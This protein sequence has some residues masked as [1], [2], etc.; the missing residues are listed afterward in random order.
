MGSEKLQ[1]LVRMENICGNNILNHAR[2]SVMRGEVAGVLGMNNAGKTELLN[3]LTGRQRPEMGTVYFEDRP[4]FISSPACANALGIY[5]IH[6][7]E[8]ILKDFTVAENILVMRKK[9]GRDMFSLKRIVERCNQLLGMLFTEETGVFLRAEDRMRDLDDLQRLAAQIVKVVS[10][11]AKLIVIDHYLDGFPRPWVDSLQKW[12]GL[13]SK[14]LY[15]SFLVTDHRS[16]NLF[17]LCDRIFVLRGG[18]NAGTFE[19]GAC[20]EQTLTSVMTGNLMENHAVPGRTANEGETILEFCGA[21]IPGEQKKL[22]LRLR[23]GE[24]TG[25]CCM[26]NHFMC[27]FCDTLTGERP[28]REGE[29]VLDGNPVKLVS[30]NDAIDCGIGMVLGDSGLFSNMGFTENV[31]ITALRKFSS[32]AGIINNG[33]ASLAMSEALSIWKQPYLMSEHANGLSRYT[34]KKLLISRAMAIL[35]RVM[36]YQNLDK[37]LDDI[38]YDRLIKQILEMPIKPKASLFVSSNIQNLI[39]VCTK[40]CFVC[41]GEVVLTVYPSKMERETLLS[42]YRS[43]CEL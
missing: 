3:I 25:L 11:N 41:D 34:E 35:P 8:Q 17:V 14:K 33:A 32:K 36:I 39:K 26:S 2:L 18:M 20:D 31:S 4:V 1:E 19:K 16:H 40:I 6:E 24:M 30:P 37:G 13:L 28:L 21:R 38:A 43:F 7:E 23:A 15:L 5:Y 22:D 27:G 9:P 10:T 12:L 42:Y 29:I